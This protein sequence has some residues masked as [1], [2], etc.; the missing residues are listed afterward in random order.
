MKIKKEGRYIKLSEGE[1]GIVIDGENGS[2]VRIEDKRENMYIGDFKKGRLFR[3]IV[4][5]KIWSSRHIDSHKQK[6]KIKY[7]SKGIKILYSELYTPFEKLPVSAVVNIEGEKGEIFFS[8][9]IENRGVS[10]VT[11]II[12]PIVA[13]WKRKKDLMVMGGGIELEP[14]FLPHKPVHTTYIRIHQRAF[15]V[16]PTTL[17]LPWVDISNGKGGI[18]YINYMRKPRNGGVYVENLAG[19]NKEHSVAFGWTHWPLIK[20]GR[21]WTSPPVGISIHKGGWYETSDKYNRWVSNWFSPP[22]STRE[23][24][25]EIGFQ[26]VFLRNFDGTPINPLSSIPQI[27][28]E[29]RKYGVKH[30]CIWDYMTLGNYSKHA[31]LDLLDYKEEEKEILRKG[32]YQAKREGTNVSALINFRLTNPVSS[33]YKTQSHKEVVRNFDGSIR[34]ENYPC[35]LY[36]AQSKP[37]HFGP[38]SYVLSSRSES[39]RKRVLEQTEEYLSLGYTSMFFDQ[40]FETFPDYGNMNY[41]DASPD[42]VYENTV[43]LLSTVREILYRNDPDAIM[44]GEQGEIFASQYIDVWMAWY[45]NYDKKVYKK[46]EKIV[47]SMPQTIHSW[48]VDSDKYEANKG[49]STGS[50]LCFI[51]HGCEATLEAEKS[52]ALH[53]SKLSSLRKKCA[54]RISFGNFKHKLGLDIKSDNE[55]ILVFSYNS[56]KGPAVVIAGGKEGGKVSVDLDVDLF[57]RRKE[58]GNSTIFYLD[59]R[60]EKVKKSEKMNFK[61]N[62]YEVVVWFW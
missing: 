16:Y 14:S 38:V 5:S 40:P 28:E 18:S 12:F 19:Y 17:Y 20:R 48:V 1:T 27:A 30:L 55:E 54:E 24:R 15:F 36:N 57:T 25:N 42:D 37:Y 56:K 35:S 22:P 2:I 26:N 7:S 33:L 34:Q 39:F 46:F 3:L 44:I 21:K 4:P 32:L 8:I 45:G 59:E 61:I 53:I 62:P 51:T 31:D 23:I 58:K 11:E 47:Y 60:V 6:A 49:F 43:K 41:K 50:W 29:G 52:F 10:P 9:E 13:G